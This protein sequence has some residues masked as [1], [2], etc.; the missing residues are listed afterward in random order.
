MDWLKLTIPAAPET[1]DTVVARLVALGYDSLQIEDERDY[2]DFI[3]EQSP[4]WDYVDEAVSAQYEGVCRVVI[5]LPPGAKIMES[6]SALQGLFGNIS[7]ENVAQSSWENS[8]KQYY[9]PTPVG[10]KLLIQPAWEPV[11]NPEGRAVFLNNPGMSFGTGLHATTS[12]CLELLENTLAPGM[13]TLDLG[14]GSGILSICAL[15]LGAREACAVDID[16]MAAEIAQENAKN[17]GFTDCYRALAGN[18]LEDTALYG[19]LGDG[20]DVVCSNIVADVILAL[21]PLVRP[22]IAEAGYWIVSG[23]IETRLAE[24]R[25]ALT[26]DGWRELECREADGW[27]GLKLARSAG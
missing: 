1:L 20:W 22:I 27:C 7:T 13:R 15:H 25:A 5:Y 23:L 2:Q 10:E 8:W 6:V 9:K 4:R 3:T 24:V 19:S 16:P 18:V 21:S 12:I 17:N 14:C 11:C 26:A